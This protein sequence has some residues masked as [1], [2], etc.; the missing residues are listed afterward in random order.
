MVKAS[1]PR[2]DWLAGM[3]VGVVGGYLTL[4]GGPIGIAVLALAG[5]LIG[6]NDLRLP[7]TGGLLLGAGGVGSIVLFG[8]TRACE[9]EA[10]ITEGSCSTIG[11][12]PWIAASEAALVLGLVLT[13]IA[14]QRIAAQR[15]HARRG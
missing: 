1:R 13:A 5:V 7:A 9:Q 12:G 2:T 11:A 14:A 3:L 6:R 4:E 8:V 15:P 10:S